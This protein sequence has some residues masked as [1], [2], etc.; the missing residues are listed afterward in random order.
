MPGFNRGGFRPRFGPREEYDAVC[1][2]CKKPCKVPFKPAKDEQGN[3]RP[4][5][6]KECFMKRKAA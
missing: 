4:V 2:E 3:L 1:A 5:Y 6:C